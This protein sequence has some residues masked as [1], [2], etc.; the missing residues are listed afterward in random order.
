MAATRS[1]FRLIVSALI[2]LGYLGG[3]SQQNHSS[4]QNTHALDKRV[5]GLH[6][7]ESIE[8]VK[9]K[10]GAPIS[11]FIDGHG[12]GAL[13]YSGWQIGFSRG[14]LTYRIHQ[15]RRRRN[16]YRKM[17]RKVA[18]NSAILSLRRGMPVDTV[19]ATLGQPDV[20]EDYY[21]L[22]PPETVLRYGPWEIRFRH[23]ML[24]LRTQW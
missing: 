9:T 19:I 22:G 7:G 18:R 17:R 14:R 13:N 1:N 6:N 23:N 15:L 12:S 5:L 3:C 8:V 24:R 10:L 4:L 11:E 16:G 21:G 20:V 2:L